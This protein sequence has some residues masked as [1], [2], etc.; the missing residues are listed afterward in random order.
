MPAA[1]SD[2]LP[3]GTAGGAA[4]LTNAAYAAIT[5]ANGFVGGVPIPKESF[6]KAMRQ[7]SVIASMIG[8]FMTSQGQNAYDN[9]DLTTLLANYVLSLQT[10]VAA[11]IT[12]DFSGSTNQSLATNGYQLLP[13]GV[14]M[15][16]GTY[17]ND[18]VG[19]GSS[20]TQVT[21]PFNTIAGASAAGFP[22]GCLQLQISC[23]NPTPDPTAD[24]TLAIVSTSATQFT[25]TTVYGAGVN[26][27]VHGFLWFAIGH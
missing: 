19:S 24:S 11:A 25:V 13:G 8:A 12:S 10:V 7:G 4:V 3:F 21:V 23:R 9:G 22:A 18:I 2:F 1:T 20:E 16:W 15:M 26:N 6:N 5:P 27:L 17:P 14:I